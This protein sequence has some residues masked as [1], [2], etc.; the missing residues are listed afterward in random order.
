MLLGL[1]QL[2]SGAI[3]DVA[4]KDIKIAHVDILPHFKRLMSIDFSHGGQDPTVVLCGAYD[5]V[6]EIVYVYNGFDANPK[7][8]LPEIARMIVPL[9]NKGTIPIM[10][11]PDQARVGNQTTMESLRNL[12]ENDGVTFNDELAGNWHSDPTGKCRSKVV[13]IEY[14]RQLMHQGKFKVC[15]SLDGWFREYRQYC[16]VK[17][18]PIDKDD[19]YMD[20]TRYLVTALLTFGVTEADMTKVSNG[21]DVFKNDF[22]VDTFLEDINKGYVL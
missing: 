17:G 3:Y 2:G 7:K 11:P 21:K 19:H 5:P 12:Y 1:P 22:D 14:I 9:Q 6:R 15:A 4:E 16:W 8:L 20:A 10:M 18:K 13:G